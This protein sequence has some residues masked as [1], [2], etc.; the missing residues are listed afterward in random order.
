MR[1]FLKFTTSVLYIVVIVAIAG[2]LMYRTGSFE[3]VI[4]LERGQSEHWVA[5]P[6]EKKGIFALAYRDL[7]AALIGFDNPDAAITILG[8][9]GTYDVEALPFTLHL[10]K[11]EIVEKPARKDILEVTCPEQRFRLD[12][13]I[14]LAVD[15][16][17]G[18][19]TVRA[20]EPWAGLVRNARGSPM[21]SV[22]FQEN[23]QQWHAPVFAEE[24]HPLHP[25]PGTMV[26]LRFYP[27]EAAARDAFPE[28][29]EYVR[30]FRWG[31]REEGRIHWFDSLTPGTGV[32]TA[33]ATEYT[34][35]DAVLPPESETAHITVKRK[36][37]A[38]TV[39]K[40]V[41]ANNISGGDEILFEFYENA[42]IF[43]IHS[44]CDGKALV[45]PYISG[46]R[47]EESTMR[48]GD[49]L[50][51]S[52]A[53]GETRCLRMDQVIMNAVPVPNFD[54]GVKALVLDTPGGV[55]RLR[56]GMSRQIDETRVAYR[57]LFQAPAVRYLLK[58]V[59][60]SQEPPRE[61]TLD[62]KEH[63]RID[64][65]QF[66]HD[67]DNLEAASIA[68]LRA[69]RIPPVRGLYGALLFLGVAAA[70]LLLI[71]NRI[72]RNIY[73]T[74]VESDTMEHWAPVEETMSENS[75][76]K[77]LTRTNVRDN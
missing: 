59:W 30:E 35:I 47:G 22:A 61:F 65:W 51:V 26:L 2:F 42:L 21:A 56:E 63:I 16:P 75:L 72:W 44:W 33:D 29:S 53:G 28:K 14:G 34:L 7:P 31:V 12:V 49:S 8:D 77:T 64:N 68:V 25:L 23:G 54:K 27:G 45:T 40:K 11:V 70:G 60:G 69:R 71:R 18:R 46:I 50:T 39:L 17:E 32:T 3:G 48:E 67:V 66:C 76:E 24:G 74:S 57:R 37:D 41:D 36:K 4:I 15:V 10:K 19:L 5:R 43:L 62:P 55:L 9:Q 13:A 6:H 1:L 58:A 73:N 38:E 20:L 52:L